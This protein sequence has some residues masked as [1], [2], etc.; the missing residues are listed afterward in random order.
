MDQILLQ[1]DL[2]VNNMP[3]TNMQLSDKMSSEAGFFNYLLDHVTELEFPPSWGIALS[4][5]S[6]FLLKVGDN[7]NTDLSV[8][9]EPDMSVKA[10]FRGEHIKYLQWQKPKTTTDVCAI[11]NVINKIA[12]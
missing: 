10:Y 4:P 9:I 1:Q 7:L 5:R 6:I 8:I 3:I 12:F 11:I 2:L